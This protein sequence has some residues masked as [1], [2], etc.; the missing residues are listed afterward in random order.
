MSILRSSEL[1]INE[2]VEAL[3]LL[4]ANVYYQKIR[5]TNVSAGGAQWNL[6]SPNRR[7]LLLSYAVVEWTLSVNRRA[8]GTGG[9]APTID[10]GD[11]VS[12]KGPMPYANAMQSATVSI[13]GNTKTFSQPRRFIEPLLR[14]CVSK[15]ENNCFE[16]GWWDETGGNYCE[17]RP[18][19]DHH[20]SWTDAG[21]RRN[22]KLFKTKIQ[23][24]N[25]NAETVGN[26][27]T[28]TA[29]IQ[30]PLFVPPFNA[31]AKITT[32]CPAYQPWK[33][34][35]AV[36]PNVDRIELE[37]QFNSDKLVPGLLYF[38]YAHS[39]TGGLAGPISLSPTAVNPLSANLLLWWYEVPFDM[40]IP[41]VV[42]LQSWDIKEYVTD[43][44]PVADGAN[45]PT[46]PVST[47]L[48]QLEST[49]SMILIH[50]RRDQENADYVCF[51]NFSD[52]DFLN[53][54]PAGMGAA[55]TSHDCFMEIRS[56]DVILG[57]R[58]NV[59]S[60]SFTQRELYQLTLKN[61]KYKGFSLDF[62]EWTGTYVPITATGD[63]G[64]QNINPLSSGLQ[65]RQMSKC[66]LCFQAK[67]LAEKISPGVQFPT[68]IQLTLN[69]L[70]RD[71]VS[72]LPGALH[73]Y[74]LYTHVIRGREFLEIE[75]DRAKYQFQATPLSV[76]E[77][78][79]QPSLV[80][81]RAGA[82]SGAYVSRY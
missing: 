43:I 12:F 3:D 21:L 13:N 16:N 62:A 22:E 46:G 9:L 27:D 26:T 7:S 66:F 31:M 56:L 30:E 74:K 8:T 47:D 15:E 45:V 52:S 42:R 40:A 35:S 73:S 41:R 71:G 6:S 82:G 69:L 10:D 29:T 5:S 14:T 75:R 25:P 65:R 67:D 51:S 24:G 53:T 11:Q 33:W 72:G 34:Q 49:P 32:G 57:D 61:S 18:G 28:L 81:S 55:N 19:Q 36:I 70:A 60:T 4:P 68:S 48:I 1:T 54:N 64:D 58:P 37:L 20:A 44:G 63:T 79:V 39:G 59:I 23:A 38:R 2:Y 76:A 77:R 50:A 78:A 17:D 80:S